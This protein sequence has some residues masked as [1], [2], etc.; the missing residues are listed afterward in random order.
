MLKGW[1]FAIICWFAVFVIG[2]M[3]KIQLL[4]KVPWQEGTSNFITTSIFGLVLAIVLK[5]LT[6]ENT[7]SGVVDIKLKIGLLLVLVPR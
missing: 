3:Y 4:N 5:L 7:G 2:T 1:F 6:K